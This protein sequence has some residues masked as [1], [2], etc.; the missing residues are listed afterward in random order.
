MVIAVI[1]H[2]AIM[3]LDRYL[4]LARTSQAL[5][6]A[7]ARISNPNANEPNIKWDRPLQAK[8]LI[9][10]L[11]IIIISYVVFWYFPMNSNKITTGTTYCDDLND[12][13]KCN[14]FQINYVLLFFYLLYM[15]YFIIA[16]L[17]LQYGLPSFRSGS[18]PLMK[19]ISKQSKFMFQIYR[20]IPFL[21]E[22]RTLV[23]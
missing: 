14:N 18:F 7:I 10:A 20:G 6:L 4:Y 5:K 22:I 8:L 19:N 17:Q 11:L 16:C 1:F 2:I 9:H 21:F 12:S 15:I 3:I 13:L 23:D